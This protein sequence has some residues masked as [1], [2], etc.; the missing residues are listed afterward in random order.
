MQ[1]DGQARGL[2]IRVA[3]FLFVPLWSSSFVTAR[4]GPCFITS[5]LFAGYAS[6]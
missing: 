4:T 3:P 5:L 2:L 1:D 6:A